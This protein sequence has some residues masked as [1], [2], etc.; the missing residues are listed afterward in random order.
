MFA[1]PS[2]W[3]SSADWVSWNWD[4]R[5]DKTIKMNTSTFL[6]AWCFSFICKPSDTSEEKHKQCEILDGSTILWHC[7]CTYF[8]L[9]INTLMLLAFNHW[10]LLVTHFWN[11]GGIV[12]DRC[13]KGLKHLQIDPHKNC[14]TNIFLLFGD[15]LC[16]KKQKLSL[17]GREIR[18]GYSKY[19]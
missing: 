15:S 1:N 4:I 8:Q 2:G 19:A 12:C 10:I 11:V 18:S 17:L 7:T 9:F 6:V 5:W 14:S 16:T 3:H 13:Q